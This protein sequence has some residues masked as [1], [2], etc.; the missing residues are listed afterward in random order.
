MRT[1]LMLLPILTSLHGAAAPSAPTVGEIETVETLMNFRVTKGNVW[2]DIQTDQPLH[3]LNHRNEPVQA[4]CDADITLA[5]FNAGTIMGGYLAEPSTHPAATSRRSELTSLV[6]NQTWEAL[7]TL[8]KNYR[9]SLGRVAKDCLGKELFELVEDVRKPAADVRDIVDISTLIAAIEPAIREASPLPAKAPQIFA[10]ALRANY[11]ALIAFRMNNR[12]MCLDPR[13]AQQLYHINDGVLVA[14]AKDG[15]V[16]QD[17]SNLVSLMVAAIAN[18]PAAVSV[19][20]V[21]SSLSSIFFDTNL[22]RLYQA[23]EETRRGQGRLSVDALGRALCLESR[24]QTVD[25]QDIKDTSSLLKA[26][27]EFFP[28]SLRPAL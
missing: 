19:G 28:E 4:A 8:A 9:V 5:P 6:S 2:K 24:V 7:L 12:N 13:T 21:A 20:T 16:K 23:V 14:A 26:V 15:D 27:F 17:L 25:M 1:L 10:D 22:N 18:P 11:D 3:R